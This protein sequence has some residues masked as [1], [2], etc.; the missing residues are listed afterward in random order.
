MLKKDINNKSEK[1]YILKLLFRIK[2]IS[3]NGLKPP[4]EMIVNA[5]LKASKSLKLIIFNTK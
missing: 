1:I 2:L 4:D 3:F 5:K